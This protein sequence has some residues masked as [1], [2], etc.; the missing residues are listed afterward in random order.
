MDQSRGMQPGQALGNG[1]AGLDAVRHRQ[2]S[3]AA[4]VRPQRS[5]LV[6]PGEFLGGT[7]RREGVHRVGQ[8]HHVVEESGP[9][10]P[11]D[12]EDLD[13]APRG[14]GNRFEPADSGELA[15]VRG[16]G[17]EGIPSDDLHRPGRSHD[18]EGEPDFPIAATTHHPD[19]AMVG[20]DGDRG[21]AMDSG[22]QGWST[23]LRTFSSSARRSFPTRC[24]A[25]YTLMDEVWRFVA[26]RASGTS[27]IT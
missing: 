5:W 7:G 1:Q 24:F 20:N 23:V 14:A 25:R 19:E 12:V 6:V 10:V 26:T 2:A 16:R 4:Q 21:R 18:V 27:W 13:Q 11:A 3:R 9:V 15:L 22:D 8:L 17:L